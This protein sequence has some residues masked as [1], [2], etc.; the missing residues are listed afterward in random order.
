MTFGDPFLSELCV[1]RFDSHIPQINIYQMIILGN[2]LLFHAALLVFTG[3]ENSFSTLVMCLVKSIN[4][5]NQSELFFPFFY[6][7]IYFLNLFFIGVQFTNIQ[8]NPQFPSPIHSHVH[9]SIIY[10]SQD[11]ETT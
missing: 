4:T 8:N 5:D 9:Y 11:M 7:F 3:C 1:I 10:R 6:L 2:R